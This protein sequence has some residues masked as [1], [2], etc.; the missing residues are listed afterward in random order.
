MDLARQMADEGRVSSDQLAAEPGRYLMCTRGSYGVTK[1]FD[2]VGP[3]KVVV[4]WSMW[5]GYWMRDGC[6]IRKWA[7]RA[8]VEAH[9]VH[10][11]GH[12]WPEDL[13][14]L[15]DAIAAKQ[16][17]PVHTDASVLGLISSHPCPT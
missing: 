10:S 12:A 17:V 2:K 4:V 8:G 13:K 1:L 16:T 3:D 9:L 11:G 15:E 6:A 7:E 5:G 14:R